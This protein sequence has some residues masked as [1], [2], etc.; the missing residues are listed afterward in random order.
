MAWKK[1]VRPQRESRYNTCAQVNFG[2]GGVAF[3]RLACELLGFTAEK[4]K[5]VIF[6]VDDKD[7]RKIGF[8]VLNNPQKDVDSVYKV[9]YRAANRTAKV[10]ARAMLAELNVLAKVKVARSTT[11]PISVDK[12]DV[13][14]VEIKPRGEN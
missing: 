13:Y 11:F 14:Y 6:M 9:S 12:G 8:S 7:P 4:P 1:I 3:N 5:W 10:R 2:P